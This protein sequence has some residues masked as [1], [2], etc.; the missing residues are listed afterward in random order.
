MPWRTGPGAT[1]VDGCTAVQWV[2]RLQQTREG[3]HKHATSCNML[4]LNSPSE[5]SFCSLRASAIA[6]AL[7]IALPRWLQGSYASVTIEVGGIVMN[8]PP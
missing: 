4:H 3:E 7:S 2:Q 6:Q 5:S 8:F 1:L